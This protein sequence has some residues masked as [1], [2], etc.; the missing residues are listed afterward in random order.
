MLTGEELVAQIVA[1]REPALGF[2][3]IDVR[4]TTQRGL[5]DRFLCVDDDLWHCGHSFNG[6][7]T[8][9]VSVMSRVTK[10]GEL[11]MLLDE[12]FS[13]AGSFEDWWTRR[14]Q[15]RP[16]TIRDRVADMLRRA[17]SAIGGSSGP[18]DAG[19]EDA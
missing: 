9:D 3:K 15:P 1:M 10:P 18:K 19:G 2:G 16:R 5:H 17:A 13:A 11:L 7:G 4:A 12:I 6:V 8:G 14:S